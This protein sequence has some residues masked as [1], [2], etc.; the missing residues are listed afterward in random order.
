MRANPER[1]RISLRIVGPF[2]CAMTLPSCQFFRDTPLEAVIKEA[3]A[4][5]LIKLT[6]FVSPRSRVFILYPYQ[7]RVPD[8]F[9]DNRKVNRLIAQSQLAVGEGHWHLMSLQSG[10]LESKTFRVSRALDVMTSAQA[11]RVIDEWPRNFRPR[12]HSTAERARL[13][14]VIYKRRNYIVLGEV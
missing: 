11:I 9:P 10:K 5:D 6:G 4:G 14:K 8:S 2:L 13:I 7:N 12:Y 1:S 3:A